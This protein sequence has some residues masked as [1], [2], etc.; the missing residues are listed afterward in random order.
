MAAFFVSG[1]NVGDG[2]WGSVEFCE[3]N[4]ER[5]FGLGLGIGAA[6]FVV[7]LVI[8]AAGSAGLGGN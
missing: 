5:L 8:G 1:L 3:G 4:G 2:L 6:A 7:L